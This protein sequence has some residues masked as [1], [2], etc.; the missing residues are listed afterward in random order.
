VPHVPVPHEVIDPAEFETPR[1]NAGQ[2]LV[3]VVAAP[4]NPADVLTLTGE[5]GHLPPLPTIGGREGAGRVAELGA[6]TRDITVGQ[7]VLLPLGCGTWPTHVVTEAAHLTPLPG[8]ADPL[9]LS[10]MTINPPTAVLLL[11]EFVT[12]GPTGS[13]KTRP[14]RPWACTWCSWPGTA[15]TRPIN[16]VRGRTRPRSC[17][18]PRRRRSR[19]WRG[20][21]E[22]RHRGDC[23]SGGPPRHRCGRRD[24]HRTAGRLLV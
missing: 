18:R 21:G 16:V 1:L 7:L 15:G 17:A 8:E 24:R 10:T 23:R 20:S 11:S 6:D 2:A 9:Q 3:E 13:S 4:T 22:T 14:T 12:L 19:R 5:Y